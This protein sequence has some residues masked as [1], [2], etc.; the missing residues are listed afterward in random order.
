MNEIERIRQR[1]AQATP[2]VWITAP[3]S[4]FENRVI[5][6]SGESPDE[7][8]RTVIEDEDARPEDLAFIAAAPQDIALL[9]RY[10]TLHR[11]ALEINAATRKQQAQPADPLPPD[12][13]AAH[14]EIKQL[15]FRLAHANN[16]IDAMCY[17]DAQPEEAQ[18]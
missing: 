10:Y 1:L 13:D 15:R 18:P 5:A 3:N 14:A 17:A 6:L 16:V 11:R 8:Y 7:T 4:I 9:L 12:L 2:G